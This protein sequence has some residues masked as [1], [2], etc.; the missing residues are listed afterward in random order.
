MSP[1]TADAGNVI[2]LGG[3]LASTRHG[4]CASSG[5]MLPLSTTMG[6]SKMTLE[7]RFGNV[8]G[9]DVTTTVC[10]QDVGG[11][12]RPLAATVPGIT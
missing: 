8:A 5:V 10:I 2:A 7:M 3:L 9:V 1:Q 4:P 6:G 11:L 12:G